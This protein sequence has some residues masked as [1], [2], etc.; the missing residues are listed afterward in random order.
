MSNCLLGAPRTE[1]PLELVS[2]HSMHISHSRNALALF[3]CV[4]LFAPNGRADV[5]AIAAARDNTLYANTVSASNGAGESFFTGGNTMSGLRRSVIAFDVAGAIPAGSTITNVELRLTMTMTMAGPL[6]VDIHRATSNWGEGTSDA[7]SGEGSGTA[8]TTGDATW[9][10]AFWPSTTWSH[11]GGD[12]A[13]LVSAT[14]TVDQVG[15]YTWA[16]TPALVAEVQSW[17]DAPASNYGWLLTNADETVQPG[18]KRF[19]SRQNPIAGD[20]PV[21]TITYLPPCGPL[22]NYCVAAPNSTGLGALI[23]RTGS[24]SIGINTFGLACNQLPPSAPYIFFVG[25][26][27]LQVPFGN[28]WRCVGGS[29]IRLTPPGVTTPQ[30][31]GARQLDF[32]TPPLVGQVAAGN[33]RYFQCWYRNPAAGGAGFNLSDGLQI[34]FCP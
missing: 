25:T 29:T 24:T 33:V 15:A 2:I 30:G 17:L 28:G 34:T 27:Q 5:F 23:S 8:A 10:H 26:S 13:L 19:A 20:R 31:T 21:L 3:A 6:A 11:V 14:Q 18:S 9:T 1:Q 4:A 16:S 32:T 12:F 7:P 22:T